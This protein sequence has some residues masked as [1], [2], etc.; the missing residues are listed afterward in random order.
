MLVVKA[1]DMMQRQSLAK[2]PEGGANALTTIGT[3]IAIVGAI[4]L[5]VLAE[6]QVSE[7]PR[8]FG[9]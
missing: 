6:G 2:N 3:A 4:I 8:G 9:R 5:F 1:I 7:M